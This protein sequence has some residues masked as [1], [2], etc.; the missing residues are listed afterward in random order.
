MFLLKIFVAVEDLE[1]GFD[2]DCGLVSLEDGLMKFIAMLVMRIFVMVGIFIFVI[3]Y[4]I[5]YLLPCSCQFGLVYCDGLGW[6][7][8]PCIISWIQK[9]TGLG[10][11]ATRLVVVLCS[12]V[13][14]SMGIV[15]G[16]VGCCFLG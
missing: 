5:M 3:C 12:L 6:Q 8:G 16:L 2:E 10:C 15:H 9:Y 4:W 14:V 1:S 11:L 7:V 13:I